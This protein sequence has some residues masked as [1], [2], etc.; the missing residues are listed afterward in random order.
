MA[1][2]RN[3]TPYAPAP[4][5]V[6]RIGVLGITRSPSPDDAHSLDWAGTHNSLGFALFTL[7]TRES[8]TAKL[9]EALAAYREALK[10]WTRE[11]VPLGWARPRS[12]WALRF[13]LLENARAGRQSSKRPSPPFVRR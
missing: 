4:G 8:G 6:H 1:C 9:E 7:G 2:C 5:Y 11:R 10:E 3:V 13:P 12:T